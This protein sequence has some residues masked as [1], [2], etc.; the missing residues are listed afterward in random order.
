MEKM[1]SELTDLQVEYSKVANSKYKPV[2]LGSVNIRSN[3]SISIQED[4]SLTGHLKGLAVNV[5]P[6]EVIAFRKTGMI[7]CIKLVFIILI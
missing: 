4:P 6:K 7:W 3:G 2:H 1:E 5:P